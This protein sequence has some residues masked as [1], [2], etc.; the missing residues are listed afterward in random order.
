MDRI[1]ND[2]G[3]RN[4]I[5]GFSVFL[6]LSLALVLYER[7]SQP[8]WLSQAIDAPVGSGEV[9]GQTDTPDS[10]AVQYRHNIRKLAAIDDLAVLENA[11]LALPAPAVYQKL[12]W[13]LVRFLAVKR[14]PDGAWSEQ[15]DRLRGEYSWLPPGFGPEL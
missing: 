12:H 11:V 6:F 8:N 10:L 15:W 3:E 4:L 13:R 9:L 2:H 7:Q 5:V 14:Q 1:N